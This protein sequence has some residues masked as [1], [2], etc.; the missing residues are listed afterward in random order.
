VDAGRGLIRVSDSEIRHYGGAG[1]TSF[2]KSIDN[3]ETWQ[4]ESLPANYPDCLGLTKEGP[5]FLP[6]A[7]DREFLRFSNLPG[8]I[9]RTKDGLDG[10]WHQLLSTDGSP[11][12]LT[13]NLQKPMTVNDGSRI[14]IPT[15]SGGSRTWYSDDF[16][17]TW[18][19]SNYIHAPPHRP[20]GI[21]KGTRWNHD[22]AEPSVV[23]LSDGRLW[24]LIRTAQDNHYE[25]FSEDFGES[26]SDPRPSR[27]HG[28][29]TMPT[30]SRLSDGRLLLLWCNTTPMPEREGAIGNCEDVFTNRDAQHAAISED[31]GMTW[32]GFREVILDEHRNNGD[33][34]VTPGSNDRAKQ[35]AQIVQL[36]E[37]RVLASI[38]QHPL[39]RKLIII[40]VRWLYETTRSDDFS[41]GLTN[42]STHM[43]I[44]E[45]VGHC[46]YNRKPGASLIGHPDDPSHQVLH[47][48][49]PNDPEL[50]C[51]N[52][53]AVWNFPA[54]ASGKLE[55]RLHIVPGSQGIRI[56]LLDRWFNP[57][58]VTAPMFAQ[59]TCLLRPIE[60]TEGKW[61][62]LEYRWTGECCKFFINGDHVDTLPP[63]Q[64][65]VNGISY[66]HIQ[67][68]AD[69]EDPY[70]ALIDYVTVETS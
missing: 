34:G 9:Y 70:G 1:S 57:T 68:V 39:H 27:F 40:D 35:Q 61:H 28:T 41:N 8:F 38:G 58:D 45:I 30:I 54:G 31:D 21:H 64:A 56:C 3:G 51:E 19:E 47:V 48:C 52:Q 25:S 24:M 42:W 69:S 44:D 20:G 55:M 6:L 46:T 7:D 17:L 4:E 43:F 23:E 37:N 11:I 66:L 14:L 26:W 62:M 67:S 5:M 65:T 33:Y 50:V 60:L 36:D 12:E 10:E 63:N 59:F 2:L 32:I 16:G 49:R 53:G 22:A 18:N 13:G 29:I 15:S